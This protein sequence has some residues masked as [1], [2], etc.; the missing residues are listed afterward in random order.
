MSGSEEIDLVVSP[1]CDWLGR[2]G[3]CGRHVCTVNPTRCYAHRFVPQKR[4]CAALRCQVRCEDKEGI[5]CYRHKRAELTR[6][7]RRA[8]KAARATEAKEAV[9]ASTEPS[10]P[11]V[12]L[13]GRGKPKVSEKATEESHTCAYKRVKIPPRK[14]AKP[15]PTPVVPQPRF[16]KAA[17]ALAASV[18]PVKP[19]KAGPQKGA[20][21]VQKL[22]KAD[23]ARMR[24]ILDAAGSSSSSSSEASS[25]GSEDTTSSS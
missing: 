2:D 14:E 19:S 17:P 9:A 23:L 1:K 12:K 11:P 6:D 25:G 15:P 10:D 4:Y 3:V 5:L 20:N 8:E 21:N 22:S 7:Q 16:K 24:A 13:T 18:S